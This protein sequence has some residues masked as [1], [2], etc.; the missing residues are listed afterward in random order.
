M[1]FLKKEIGGLP[2]WVWG[3]VI[4]AGIGVGYLFITMQ[5]KKP[6][7]AEDTTPVA[8]VDTGAAPF[9][10][11]PGPAGPPGPPGPAGPPGSIG[12]TG[13]P[14]GYHYDVVK[15]KCV[16][17]PKA[18]HWDTTVQTCVKNA[19]PHKQSPM[20]EIADSQEY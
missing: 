3:L 11:P 18:H 6:S 13:C 5:N 14:P 10:G 4:I 2:V 19:P 9:P 8:G 1:E 15:L 7:P 16:K 20:T 12:P 17:C